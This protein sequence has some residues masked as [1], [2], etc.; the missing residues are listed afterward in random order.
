MVGVADGH[1]HKANNPDYHRVRS[2]RDAGRQLQA[3]LLL[4]PDQLAD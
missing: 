4:I 3:E 2:Q 1:T